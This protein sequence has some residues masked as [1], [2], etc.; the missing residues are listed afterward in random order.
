MPKNIVIFAD[1][2]AQEGGNT[3]VSQLFYTVENRT[4]GQLALYLPG[5]GT[6][7]RKV[8]GNVGGMGI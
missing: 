4:T 5:V 6:E 3:N 1:G 2:T 7:Q 8:T